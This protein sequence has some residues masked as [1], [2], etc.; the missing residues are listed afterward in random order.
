MKRAGGHSCHACIWRHDSLCE[1]DHYFSALFRI[2]SNEMLRYSIL[3]D[4][5]C[6]IL[7]S[8]IE[9]LSETLTVPSYITQCDCHNAIPPENWELS[10]V[11]QNGSGVQGDSLFD[12]P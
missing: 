1:E 11:E 3:P 2:F 7:S 6:S 4:Y 5:N 12:L 10:S 8:S 9:A